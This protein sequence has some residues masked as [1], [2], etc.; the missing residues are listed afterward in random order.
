MTGTR[1]RAQSWW[2]AELL[3][4][5]PDDGVWAH[6][7]SAVTWRRLREQVA[8]SAE[9]FAVHGIRAGSS[10]ALRLPPS[11]TSI[12]SLLALW[13]LGA[14]VQL[15]DHRLKPAEV[16]RML[17][18]CEPSCYVHFTDKGGAV[19]AFQD[20]CEVFVEWRR[21]GRDAVTDHCLVQFSSGSTGRPKVIARSPQSLQA[22]IERFSRIEGMPRAGEK[23]LLLNSAIHSLGLVGGVLHALNVGA[24]LVFTPRLQPDALAGTLAQHGIHA[25]FGVP[26]HYDLLSRVREVPPLAHLRLAVSGGEILTPEVYRRFQD[27]YGLAV[28][29]AYGMTETGII[30]TDLPGRFGPPA[31]G[32]PAPGV[33][34][35]LA[36]GELHVALERSPYLQAEG[37][38][39]FSGGWLRTHDLCERDEASGCL[40]VSGR[41]DSLIAVG[42][43][44]VDLMEIESVLAEHPGVREVVVVH[45]DGIEAHLALTEGTTVSELTAF[46]RT[47]LSNYKIPK[48]FHAV[49]AVPR[50]ANGKLLRNV[51]L[52][53]AAY[54]Q[55]AAAARGPLLLQGSAR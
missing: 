38:E 33:R 10:V 25:V 14:Q 4:G 55:P 49:D 44:K 18:L 16:E 22:E 51:Q 29:Q 41:S 11:L 23:V 7:S 21:T 52:L 47:R 9:V 34:T 20:E 5:Q 24:T 28:G 32:L 54:A 6:G 31:V 30:A 2:G 19:P 46:A 48:R 37:A 43:L 36:G 40:R 53:H 15:L 13:S 17:A 50:T 1:P 45:G 35:K 42:G 27:R 8:L 12:V 26:F 3:V 39:R